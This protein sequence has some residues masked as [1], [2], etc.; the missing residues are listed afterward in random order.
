MNALRAGGTYGPLIIVIGGKVH[1]SHLDLANPS[2]K[3][4]FLDLQPYTCFY[5]KCAWSSQPFADRQ[6]WSNHLE[7]DHNLGPN[8]DGVECPLCLEVTKSGKSA[9]LIHFARHMEDISLAAL[10]REVDSDAESEVDGDSTSDHTVLSVDANE[11]IVSYRCDLCGHESSQKEALVTHLRENHYMEDF[12]MLHHA[13][14]MTKYRNTWDPIIKELYVF[15]FLL[16][17]S[18]ITNNPQRAFV[19]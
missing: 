10:P 1:R 11:M 2:R 13:E 5:E 7:L 18:P 15:F 16:K 4:L 12:Q 14:F 8:W 3:H 19:F 9:I 6:L 17:C